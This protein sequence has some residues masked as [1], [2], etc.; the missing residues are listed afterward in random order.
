[1]LVKLAIVLKKRMPFTGILFFGM[2]LIKSMLLVK[3]VLLLFLWRMLLRV[4]VLI[5]VWFTANGLSN[6]VLEGFGSLFDIFNNPSDICCIADFLEPVFIC[7]T[8]S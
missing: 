6:F 5:Y 2:V 1:M 8:C 4:V 3:L 7:E